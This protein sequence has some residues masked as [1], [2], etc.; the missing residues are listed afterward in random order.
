MAPATLAMF[1]ATG[2]RPQ[3][4][5][6]T[7]SIRRPILGPAVFSWRFD[8]AVYPAGAPRCAPSSPEDG[9]LGQTCADVG[10]GPDADMMASD[11]PTEDRSARVGAPGH[12]ARQDR[13][14]RINRGITTRDR[15]ANQPPSVKVPARS[16]VQRPR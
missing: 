9:R 16:Q 15:V 2:R 13:A 3:L 10:N 1:R 11:T 8:P 7:G 4:I 6:Q 14:R 5:K 12:D